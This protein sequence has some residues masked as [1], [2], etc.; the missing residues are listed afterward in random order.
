MAAGSELILAIDQGT[1]NSK[2]LAV[3]RS[4]QVVARGRAPLKL[5]FP[6]PGW[7][8]ADAE[9]L[10]QSVATALDACLEQLPKDARL[11]GLGISNQRES[12]VLWDRATGKPLGPVIVWQCRRTTADCD[13]LREAGHEADV[14]ARTGLTLDPLFSAL[15]MRWPLQHHPDGFEAGLA[16][17]ERG[18]LCFGT[19]DSWLLWKLSG[20][21]TFATDV[22]NASRT[23]L[24]NLATGAWDPELLKLFSVPQA[25]L[26]QIVPSVPD[27]P[28]GESVACGKLPAGVPLAGVLA[29]SHAALFAQGGY[30]PGPIKVTYGTGSSLLARTAVQQ[31]AEGGL[32]STIAWGMGAG[33]K[34]HAL[35]GNIACTGAAIDWLAGILLG[36]KASEP[37]QLTGG[38]YIDSLAAQVPDAGEALMV[39][40]FTGLGAPHWDA[41]A[42]GLIAGLSRGTTAAH[43]ARATFEGVAHQICD[44]FE[45][46]AAG[47][48]SSSPTLWADGGASQ[49]QT[50]MQMQA[51]L[52]GCPVASNTEPDTSALGAA[53]AAGLTVGFWADAQE[54]AGLK[55]ERLVYEPQMS[56]DKRAESRGRWLEAVNRARTSS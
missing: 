26:P 10:W 45:L 23:Q 50:L 8:E 12:V 51:D 22:G 54:L 6:Q 18:E 31:A 5:S 46:L 19:I 40:A 25:A 38:A 28:L 27:A 32:S 17:A 2:A 1:T 20:G 21:K 44:V 41:G 43:L 33:N 7:V 11:V 36:D 13:A 47:T 39:P 48:G 56:A 4:G 53:H 37:G 55:R 34:S 35:E 3:N 9:G 16:Q 15:K 42:R 52:C 30:E 29:D 24:L 14:R 49:S